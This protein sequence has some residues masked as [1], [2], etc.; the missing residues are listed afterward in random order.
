MR[1][2]VVNSMAPFVWGGA[3][4]L[5]A[6]LVRNLNR[7]GH[8]ATLYRIPFAWEPATGIPSEI[9]RSKLIRLSSF[10]RV[11]SMKFPVY[12]LEAEHH[13]TWL[14]HQY[15][16]AYD[17]WDSPY[18]NIP[19]TAEGEAIRE[20]I[21]ANDNL[22]LG[23]RERLFTISE[24]ISVRLEDHNGIKAAPLRAPLNDP[25]LFTGG[26][27]EPYILAAGRISA[28]KRQT[29]LV[30][31]M[32]HLGRK[33]R[34]IV[35]GPPDS[36]DDAVKLRQLVERLDLQDKVKLDLRFLAREELAAYVNHSRAVAYLPYEEDSF[37]YVTMEAFEAA[38]PVI[39]ATDAGELLGIVHHDSTG[40]VS[41][42]E[43]RLLA[44]AMN[45]YLDNENLARDHGQA[46]RRRW[47]STGISWPENIAR[48]LGSDAC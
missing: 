40:Q 25:E 2:A 32:R 45:T 27:Y 43:P 4:E 24:Q 19:H 14:V 21:R 13:T 8:E 26:P 12:L 28:S 20:L 10:D 22:A 37:G 33:A 44:Q 41:A 9:A 15:R 16:Q 5:A 18:C 23:S 30:E 39:T 29:L 35:A 11:I 17:L 47:H 36:A 42:P 3:E 7:A 46:A 6:H 31:A 38:K 34:L 48:L 1:V